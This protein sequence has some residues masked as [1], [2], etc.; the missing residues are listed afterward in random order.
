MRRE[1]FTELTC[2]SCLCRWLAKSATFS[3]PIA[4]E[5]IGFDRWLNEIADKPLNAAI[6]KT[7]SEASRPSKSKRRTRR[8]CLRCGDSFLAKR[9]DAKYCSVKCRI[10][11]SRYPAG[12]TETNNNLVASGTR[13]NTRANGIDFA[14]SVVDVL[15]A[16][17]A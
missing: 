17:P 14:L 12:Q 6:P 2:N 5:E 4:F 11:V 3:L 16:H 1:P 9:R 7:N 15:Q 13:M 10:R 8:N